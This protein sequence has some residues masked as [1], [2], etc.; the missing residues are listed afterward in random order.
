M[1]IHTFMY[2]RRR[3]SFDVDLSKAVHI[4]NKQYNTAAGRFVCVGI[5]YAGILINLYNTLTLKSVS[6]VGIVGLSR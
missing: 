2:K 3:R 4:L 1:T 5:L 6:L